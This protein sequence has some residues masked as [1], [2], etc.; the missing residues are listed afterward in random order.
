MN[1][2]KESMYM[3]L[4][5]RICA[6]LIAMLMLCTSFGSLALEGESYTSSEQ[7]LILSVQSAIQQGAAYMLNPVGSYYPENG[8]SFGTLQ[9]DWAVFAL[10]RS[11]LAIPYDIWQK[12]ADNSSAAMAKAI[13]KVRAEHSDIT[14][15][16]LLHYRKRTE[17]MRAM[18]G[19]T[20]LGLDVHNVAGYDITRALG[21]YTDIIW[22][23][24]NATIFTLIALDTLNYDMPQLTYEEMSQG[25]HGTAV[26]A[27]REM[28]VTRIMSQEL[29]SGGWVLDTGFEVEDG[30]GSGS[31]TPSTDKADPDITAM[32]IQAL[33]LYSGMNV[34]VNGT[35][36]NVGDAI[37][38]GLN[39]LSAMQKSA[40]DFDSWGTTNV[41]STAQVLMAL[42]AMGIDPLKDDRF[43]TASGNTLINGILR[44]HVAGSGFRH[45]MDGSVNAMATD[46]AMYALVA[47][48]RFL[49]GKNYIYNMS[50]NLEAHAI[51]I[52]TAEHGTLSAAE[53]ASQGQRITVYA[54][55]EDGYILSDV[56][57]Y[58]YQSEI[59]FDNGVMRVSWELTPTYQQADV[60]QDGL[61]ASFTMPNV[62][63]L[64]RAEFGEGGQ[65]GESYG[66]I[67]T[68]VNGSVRVSKDSARAGER[69]LISPKPLDGYEYIEGTISAIGPNGESIALSEN[70]SGGF[71]G[72]ETS[73]S[74]E[75][76][77]TAIADRTAATSS[78]A[79]ANSNYHAWV[80][81]NSGTYSAALSAMADLTISESALNE[82]LAPVRAMLAANKDEFRI[83][84]PNSAAANGH[85]ITVSGK[86]KVGDDVT[87]TVTPADG[88]ELYLGSLKANGVKVSKKGDAYSFVMPAAD[89]AITASFCKEGT[90]PAEVKGDANGD[91]SVNIADVA[92]ICRYIMGEAQLG[93]DA[94]ELCDMNGDGSINVTDAVLVCMKVAGN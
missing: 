53:S 60:S 52:D 80:D 91:G 1:R 29:P 4:R 43:I 54:S 56:K 34:T 32:A 35:E 28:L 82:A 6:A 41:E 94:R 67:Q 44:Y 66:F 78:L 73:G 51:S 49:K 79:D 10:G 27:T 72:D 65:T 71:D 81:A 5:M 25:V 9:G 39:A 76:S 33:A 89:V 64:I 87:V 50:D 45:V 69:V 62:P 17:N 59:A 21:N 46:Q 22:Q 16:P 61:S 90:G 92:L 40:G 58:L 93:A 42:I 24:I 83:I 38:R 85:K 14:T 31:F 12:Y 47:Y 57:A 86:A 15:L 36:K 37:E 18:I 77:Y 74:F 30:D 63:V 26:Q 13:E 19:Y 23:G 55:P 7:Q 88:Y 20:S 11:G 84:L 8:L 2:N 48:D 70:A 68:S 75:H 3:K